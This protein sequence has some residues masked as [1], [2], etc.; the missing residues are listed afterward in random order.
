[1]M[2][3]KIKLLVLD[4]D[5]VLTDGSIFISSTGEPMKRFEAKDGMAISLAN[6][7]GIV[8]ALVSGRGN[9]IP[10]YRAS[11]LKIPYCF[12]NEDKKEERLRWLMDKLKLSKDEVAYMGDDLND[13]S[14]MAVAG[15]K[16]APKNAA[17]EVLKIADYVT[18]CYGGHGAV[19]EV[20]ENILKAQGKWEKIVA[21]YCN[22]G[23][24]DKQ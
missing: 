24:G 6:R 23:Q 12:E 19:R 15:V 21:D 9:N 20:V 13:L 1:M 22:T 10:N 8:L 2:F 5:G 18:E 11:E 16:I 14:P 17:P 3:K 7:S 4:V